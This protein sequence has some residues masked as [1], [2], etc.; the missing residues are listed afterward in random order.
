MKQRVGR[1]GSIS[2]KDVW[3]V[4]RASAEKRL[5]RELLLAYLV[6]LVV[7][8]V[9]VLASVLWAAAGSCVW[10]GEGAGVSGRGA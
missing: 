4:V 1:T 6:L 5:G 7:G 10:R 3:G 8:L 2:P 9:I